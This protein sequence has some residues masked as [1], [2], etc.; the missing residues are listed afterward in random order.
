[1]P[2]LQPEQR[3]ALVSGLGFS[4]ESAM[5]RPFKRLS[6]RE[7]LALAITAEEED[8][9]IYDDF[10]AGLR[11]KYPATAEVFAGMRDEEIGHRRRLTELYRERFGEH[12]PLI[13]RE[14]VKGFVRH[15]P[16]WMIW[17]RGL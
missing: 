5:A 9:R 10:A 3:H 6:E 4:P 1:M 14:D 2:V 8:S 11:D 7:F 12:I 17:P 15:P 13:R 16:P